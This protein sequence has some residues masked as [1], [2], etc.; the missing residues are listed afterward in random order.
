MPLISAVCIWEDL[1]QDEIETKI[2]ESL[3]RI[4]G[5]YIKKLKRIS[6]LLL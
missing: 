5:R 6:E 4:R 2:R 1:T 3:R